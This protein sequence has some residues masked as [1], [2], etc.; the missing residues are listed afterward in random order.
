ME[1]IIQHQHKKRTKVSLCNL[2]NTKIAEKT[3]VEKGDV[4]QKY[5][6]FY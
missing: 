5:I 3:V 1:N 4:N 6:T 2:S